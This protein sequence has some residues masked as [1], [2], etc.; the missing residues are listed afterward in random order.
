M[1]VYVYV[2]VCVCVCVC[3][4]WGL[5]S[6]IDCTLT[7]LWSRASP[8]IADRGKLGCSCSGGAGWES[9]QSPLAED[10]FALPHPPSLQA[11]AREEASLCATP[12]AGV[13]A[14]L[15]VLQ[16]GRQEAPVRGGDGV[17]VGAWGM[18][19]GGSVWGMELNEGPRLQRGGWKFS[20]GGWGSVEVA[21]EFLSN[22]LSLHHPGL[23]RMVADSR[24]DR[25]P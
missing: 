1:C 22:A 25:A 11:R 4:Y 6:V 9:G 7:H 14:P 15:M 3:V 24:G 5:G 17:W 16:T 13:R 12:R 10:Q 20:E 2:Y 23:P 19:G 18:R 21:R 8:G